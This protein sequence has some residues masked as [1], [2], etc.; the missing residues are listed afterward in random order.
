M[1]RTRSPVAAAVTS[2]NAA[3]QNGVPAWGQHCAAFTFPLSDEWRAWTVMHDRPLD[4]T[5]LASFIEDRATDASSD[6]AF[7]ESRGVVGVVVDAMK[8]KE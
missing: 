7:D 8:G 1:R 6:H 4:Q 5:T 2:T 3:S